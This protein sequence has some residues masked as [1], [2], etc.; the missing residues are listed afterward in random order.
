M[1]REILFIFKNYIFR[2][3]CCVN[4]MV[5][6]LILLFCLPI[7]NNDRLFAN[8]MDDRDATFL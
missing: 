2:T 3:L 4:K 8:K 5:L 7:N 1:I 6:L